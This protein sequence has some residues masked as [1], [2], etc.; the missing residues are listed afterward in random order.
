MMDII[1]YVFIGC[2]IVIV[3]AVG[4]PTIR[5]HIRRRFQ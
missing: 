3:L 2:S 4:H 1:A 5:K